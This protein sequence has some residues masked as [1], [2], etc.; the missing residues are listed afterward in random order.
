[1]KNQAIDPK[2]VLLGEIGLGGELRSVSHI[3]SRLSEAAKMGF[4]RAIIP[5]ANKKNLA[6]KNKLDV[7]A[8]DN[9]DEVL[10]M[11]LQ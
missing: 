7:Y 1:M 5:K 6:M 2:A 10:Q 4:K 11:V 8:A 9:A 3:E